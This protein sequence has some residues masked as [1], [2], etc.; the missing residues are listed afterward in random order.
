MLEATLAELLKHGPNIFSFSHFAMKHTTSRITNT[1][2]S[3]TKRCRDRRRQ[4]IHI[5]C[6]QPHI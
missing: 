1:K 2:I 5:I 4:R 3:L 6:I